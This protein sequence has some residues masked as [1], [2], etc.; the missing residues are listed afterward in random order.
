MRRQRLIL[1]AAIAIAVFLS[2]PAAAA[3]IRLLVNGAEIVPDVAP[4]NVA[5]RVLVPLRTV[6]ET[7]G[8]DVA[9]HPA[10]QAVTVCRG[11]ESFALP[12]DL[13]PAYIHLFVNGVELQ[14]DVPPKI[15]DGRTMVPIRA[16]A[17][18]LGIEVAWDGD[19]RA[20]IVGPLA[21]SL[22]AL[23]A[24]APVDPGSDGG[25]EPSVTVYV[26]ATGSKY[27]RRDCR[28]VEESHIPLALADAKAR[29]YVPCSV[30]APPG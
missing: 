3:S 27:H 7:L 1:A 12:P 16:V 29:H 5:G 24:G 8:Y 17:E 14:P 28:Y 26:T 2:I 4:Q 19:Y 21:L 9:W 30:C 13:D 6:A 20:V 25:S 23:V 15:I 10:E 18:A 11:G 22:S